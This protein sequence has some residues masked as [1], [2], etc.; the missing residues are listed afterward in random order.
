MANSFSTPIRPPN[1]L[2]AAAGQVIGEGWAIDLGD[3][4]NR[5]LAE[6]GCG[7]VVAQSWA[8]NLCRWDGALTAVGVWRIPTISG[9]HNLVH[10]EIYAKSTAA[11]GEV[12]V[13]PSTTADVVAFA[14]AVGALPDFYSDTLDIGDPAAGYADLTLWLG[15][16]SGGE[17][18]VDAILITHLALTSPMA[19]GL[20]GDAEPVGVAYLGSDR[21]LDASIGQQIRSGTLEVLA[22]RRVL[23]NWTALAGIS[24]LSGAEDRAP[25]EYP[26]RHLVSVHPGALVQGVEYTV[27]V[28]ARPDTAE[29]TWVIVHAADPDDAWRAAGRRLRIPADAAAAV[30]WWSTTIVLREDVYIPGHAWP[31][32][33][34]GIEA[35]HSIANAAHGRSTAE[36]LGIVIWGE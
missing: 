30:S 25:D 4:Y 31:V 12:E 36:I 28:R 13:S 33:Y 6:V 7:P 3:T 23:L 29:D 16:S 2:A 8:G 18:Q 22:R 21:A 17:T 14:P 11:V 1:P 27:W 35:D 20:V 26:L 9:A 24:A 10:V 34:V 19:A 32:L 5:T 15:N